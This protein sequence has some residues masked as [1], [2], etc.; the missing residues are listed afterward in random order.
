MRKKNMYFWLKTIYEVYDLKNLS[1]VIFLNSFLT[2][3]IQALKVKKCHKNYFYNQI[4][5]MAYNTLLCI[6][7]I[8]NLC[9]IHPF[10]GIFSMLYALL[11]LQRNLH[12]IRIIEK[13]LSSIIT[14]NTKKIVKK[15]GSENI[16]YREAHWSTWI[17]SERFESSCIFI[18]FNR[19][20]LYRHIIWTCNFLWFLLYQKFTLYPEPYG[21]FK[22]W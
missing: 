10:F 5:I 13:T 18:V 3:F 15:R 11:S 1:S 2:K 21:I 9:Y 16:W 8:S 12:R 20:Y 7:C 19:I 17:S 4:Q 14:G 22:T 6:T